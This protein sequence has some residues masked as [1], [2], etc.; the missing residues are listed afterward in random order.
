MT[1]RSTSR[2]SLVAV[3]LLLPVSIGLSASPEPRA[4]GQGLMQ[5]FPP[6]PERRVTRET[7]MIAPFNRWSFQHIR[8][9]HPTRAV[10]RDAARV[11]P[12]ASD[13]RDLGGFSAPVREGRVA[14]LDQ[15]LDA[16]HT[17]AFLV[18]HKG[19]IVYE[20]YLNGMQPD[21]PHLMFSC[22]KSFVGTMLLMLIEQGRVDAAKPVLDANGWQGA[23]PDIVYDGS[24]GELYDVREDPLQWRNLW[25]DPAWQK[26][27]RE[28]IADLY[29]NLPPA[30]SPQLAVEAPA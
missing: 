17:D 30:R 25:D 14:T 26:R 3:A 4:T 16:S 8:E 11:S 15:L 28:L 6:E 10:H 12:L 22:T 7:T 18:L 27:K 21:T 19:R 1:T 5:G 24:E 23:A 20:R 2:F 13:L 9:L 29:D